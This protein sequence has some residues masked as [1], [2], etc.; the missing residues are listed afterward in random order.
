MGLPDVPLIVDPDKFRPADQ[1]EIVGDNGRL[2][3]AVGWR[4]VI[5]IETSIA[6]FVRSAA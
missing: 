4:P 6:D 3:A 5:P 1:V 2:R